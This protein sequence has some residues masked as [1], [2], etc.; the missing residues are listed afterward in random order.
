MTHQ[1]ITPNWGTGIVLAVVLAAF[2]FLSDQDYRDEFGQADELAAVQKEEAAKAS[3][4]FA[5]RQV[6]GPG[7]VHEWID[8]KTVTCSPKRGR[9]YTV[10]EVK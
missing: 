10:A 2:C 4:E 8:D 9:V 5:G 7:A 3:R 1:P 6:C